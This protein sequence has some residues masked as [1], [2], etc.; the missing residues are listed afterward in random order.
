MSWKIVV[1]KELKK[2][3][4]TPKDSE[5]RLEACEELLCTVGD[6]LALAK[7]EGARTMAERAKEAV[8]EINEQA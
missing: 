2:V 4:E 5:A 6:Q 8:R 1:L 7:I 3:L